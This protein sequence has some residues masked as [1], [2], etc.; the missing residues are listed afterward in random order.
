M[1]WDLHIQKQRKAALTLLSVF[2]VKLKNVFNKNQGKL[3]M[4]D[5][6]IIFCQ[7]LSAGCKNKP[8]KNPARFFVP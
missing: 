5:D 4:C 6:S 1:K 8:L 2:A 7:G 3:P